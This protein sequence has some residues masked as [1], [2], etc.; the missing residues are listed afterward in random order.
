MQTSCGQFVGL[1]SRVLYLHQVGQ[2]LGVTFS[3][4]PELIL[5]HLEE[6]N[7]ASIQDYQQEASQQKLAPI[8]L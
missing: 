1:Q 4:K 8:N 3:L 5:L 7:T 2:M 6:I